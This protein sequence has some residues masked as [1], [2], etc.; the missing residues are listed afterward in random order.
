MNYKNL[1]SLSCL[2]FQ[3]SLVLRLLCCNDVLRLILV[4][5]QAQA[6]APVL[7]VYLTAKERKRIRRLAEDA[8]S[9]SLALSLHGA[10]QPL[11][12]LLMPQAAKAV[13]LEDLADAL[14]YHTSLTGQ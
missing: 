1:S 6:S 13:P 2:V 11:R 4:F 12:E 9:V 8:P 14:D 7:P 10:T 3:S 5:A